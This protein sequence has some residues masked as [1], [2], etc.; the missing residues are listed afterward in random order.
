[1]SAIPP[2]LLATSC[3]SRDV[4]MVRYIGNWMLR[5]LGQEASSQKVTQATSTFSQLPWPMGTQL[6]EVWK[7]L[8]LLEIQTMSNYPL[9]I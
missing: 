1:M 4:D 6:P 3:T 8:Q 9:V 5:Q 2:L 7:K